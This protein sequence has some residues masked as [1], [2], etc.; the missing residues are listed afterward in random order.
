MSEEELRRAYP[1]TRILV[2]SDRILTPTFDDAELF[3]TGAQ[4][5]L[6]RNL[7]G[8]ANRQNTYVATYG[9]GY[10]VMPDATDFD[11]ILAI[12]ADLEE[13]LM[14]NRN[15]L[16]GYTDRLTETTT[17]QSDVNGTFTIN[18]PAVSSGEVWRVMGACVYRDINAGQY[19]RIR[20]VYSGGATS[21]EDIS[22]PATGTLY[23][24]TSKIVLKAA[25][26]IR[27]QFFGATIGETVIASAWGYK[28]VVP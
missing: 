4:I 22:M 9:P 17:L 26:N 18:L 7:L 23:P 12:V 20:I 25:D 11:D 21:I 16:W 24:S 14:G 15:V 28:M 8:Y 3:F 1:T 27:V 10:Y 5:E 2:E 19:A 13:T 6:M